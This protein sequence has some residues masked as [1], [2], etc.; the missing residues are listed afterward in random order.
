[1]LPALIAG[2][3][4]LAGGLIA[5][6][7]ARKQV[8]AQEDANA[9]ALEAAQAHALRQE[10]LQRE[11]AQHGIRWRVEDA[12]AAGLHP[13]YALGGSTTG[14]SPSSIPVM[15]APGGAGVGGEHLGRALSDAGQNISRAVAAQESAEQ[16]VFRE[17][18]LQVMQ[19]QIREN[20]A[21][22][23]YYASEAMRSRQNPAAPFPD[24]GDSSGWVRG[25][26]GADAIIHQGRDPLASG[27]F[28]DRRSI[29]PSKQVSAS[30][31]FFGAE[32]GSSPH[33]K[34]YTFDKSGETVIDLPAGSGPAE[35]YESMGENPSLL[36]M[37]VDHNV[38]RYGLPWLGKFYSMMPALFGSVRDLAGGRVRGPR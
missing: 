14:Y 1:M 23:G 10:E 11:F 9:R 32:A 26:G 22:A 28:F 8:S 18:Q 38:S 36:W 12:K 24:L 31:S 13:L 16:R 17:T 6:R 30:S 20:D 2:G 21:R 37:V 5:A 25:G 34:S 4:A 7:S 15:A 19:S 35:A 27:P 29:E 33:W 3:A